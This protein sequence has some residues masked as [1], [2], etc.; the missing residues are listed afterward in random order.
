M[1]LSLDLEMDLGELGTR[2]VTFGVEFHPPAHGHDEQ[3][4]EPGE[5][6]I[7]SATVAGKNVYPVVIPLLTTQAYQRL[8]ADL[9]EAACAQEGF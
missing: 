7:E 2:T 4:T 5:I 6:A 9:F 3:T 1:H 8:K